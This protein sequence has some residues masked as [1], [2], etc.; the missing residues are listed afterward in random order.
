MGAGGG[1]EAVSGE[2]NSPRPGG[3]GK[4]GKCACEWLSSPGNPKGVWS[5]PL[6]PDTPTTGAPG[7]PQIGAGLFVDCLS[8]LFHENRLRC[9]TI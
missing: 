3:E 2:G 7:T 6:S 5:L 8:Q 4:G 1:N 9:G